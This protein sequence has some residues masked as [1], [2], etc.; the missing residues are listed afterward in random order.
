MDLASLF[1]LLADSVCWDLDVKLRCPRAFRSR[2]CQLN[3]T[4]T[5]LPLL[6]RAASQ[7]ENSKKQSPQGIRSSDSFEHPST[8]H[9]DLLSCSIPLHSIALPA[10]LPASYPITRAIDLE[11]AKITGLGLD[12]TR[13][14]IE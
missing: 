2:P 1:L 7:Y 6:G 5:L 4:S 11:G 14:I 3:L 12:L 8:T 13:W 10:C 9:T